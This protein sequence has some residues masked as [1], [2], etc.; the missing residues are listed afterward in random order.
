[1]NQYQDASGS[2][3]T[4]PSVTLFRT[5]C[6]ATAEVVRVAPSGTDGPAH[7]EVLRAARQFAFDPAHLSRPEAITFPTGPDPGAPD[8]PNAHANR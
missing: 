3:T 8:A 7:V 1:M 4:E 6:E 5:A 2:K